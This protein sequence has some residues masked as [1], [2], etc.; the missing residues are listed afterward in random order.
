MPTLVFLAIAF[1][2]RNLKWRYAFFLIAAANL[3]FNIY[4]GWWAPEIYASVMALLLCQ[5]NPLF[6]QWWNR[7]Y[8]PASLQQDPLSSPFKKHFMENKFEAMFWLAAIVISCFAVDQ[9]WNYTGHIAL[10]WVVGV[11]AVFYFFWK[12]LTSIVSP[13]LMNHDGETKYILFVVAASWAASELIYKEIGVHFVLPIGITL[14]FALVGMFFIKGK[15]R[16][17]VPGTAMISADLIWQIIR[18]YQTNSLFTLPVQSAEI[19]L[20]IAVVIGFIWLFKQPSILPIFF[21]TLFQLY[22]FSAFTFEAVDRASTSSLTTPEVTFYLLYLECWMFIVP[23][24]LLYT[25]VRQAT[26]TNY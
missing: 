22:R 7:S 8:A 9:Y 12:M 3:I 18:F 4:R 14:V 19:V 2:L 24:L 15:S 20:L 5:L 13:E 10:G 1:Q 11:C 16:F 21:L 26:S 25:G 6:M 23:L 17:L